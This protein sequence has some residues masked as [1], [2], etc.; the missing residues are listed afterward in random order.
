MYSLV[1][2]SGNARRAASRGSQSQQFSRRG[3][4]V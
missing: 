1:T 3:V 2:T 4:K